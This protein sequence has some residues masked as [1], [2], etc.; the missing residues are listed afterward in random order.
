MEQKCSL[1]TRESICTTQYFDV[2]N[3]QNYDLILGTP[4][5][6][7]HQVTVGFNEA[8]VVIGSPSPR[9]IKG[10]QVQTIAS[11]SAEIEEVGL[12]R[13]R[14]KLR[15]LAKPLCA[16]A[17]ETELPPLRAINHTIPLIDVNKI[18]PW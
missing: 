9:P 5:F 16:K 11:R 14:E 8:R 3:L 6:Y 1:S 15:E 12:E 7:Q 17:S 2:I 4:F 13:A 10:A 18:Y